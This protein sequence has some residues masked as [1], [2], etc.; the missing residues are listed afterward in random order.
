MANTLYL[1]KQGTLMRT[2]THFPAYGAVFKLSFKAGLQDLTQDLCLLL[3]ILWLHYLLCK[4]LIQ[5]CFWKVIQR[6][7]VKFS[8]AA[9]FGE[10]RFNTD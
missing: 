8:S 10:K 1:E 6:M 9:V 3:L 4:R 7:I 2:D 5:V